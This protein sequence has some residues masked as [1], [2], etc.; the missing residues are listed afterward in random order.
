MDSLLRLAVVLGIS[1][2]VFAV[3]AAEHVEHEVPVA[4]AGGSGPG[5]PT[6]R[7]WFGDPFLQ[8]S[9][10]IADC[11]LPAG[12]FITEAERRVQSHNRAERGTTCWLTGSCERPNFY[13]YDRDIAEALRKSLSQAHPFANTTVWATVQGRIVFIEGC[14]RDDRVAPRIEAFVAALP[15]VQRAVAIVYSDPASRPPYKLRFRP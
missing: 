10:D 1:L 9:K 6:R 7:N 13:R 2:P 11:P 12:P 15:H 8:L 5:E 4:Q 14:V 3:Q